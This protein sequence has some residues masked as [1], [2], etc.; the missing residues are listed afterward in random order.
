MRRHRRSDNLEG[1]ATGLAADRKI[2][3]A[4][5]V[6]ARA[7]LAATSW[8]GR[9]GRDA[10]KVRGHTVHLN[11]QARPVAPRI[12]KR[13]HDVLARRQRRQKKR[14]HHRARKILYIT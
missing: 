12:P 14:A 5:V 4:A 7:R 2:E 6:T 1:E 3:T 13:H 8:A 10:G 11:I 9:A